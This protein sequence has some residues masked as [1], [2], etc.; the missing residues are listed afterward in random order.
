[1]RP[2]LTLLLIGLA[3]ALAA[4]EPVAVDRLLFRVSEAEQEPY[5]SRILV[6]P[7]YVRIDEGA[8]ER[9]FILYDREKRLIYSVNSGDKTVLVIEPGTRGAGGQGGPAVEVRRTPD[10]Q[11]PPIAGVKPV[12]VSLLAGGK[13][14]EERIVAPGLLVKAL[15]GLG[16]YQRTR[17]L[18]ELATL[19]AIPADMQDACDLALNVYHSDLLLKDGLPVR[20]WRQ[21]LKEDL[22]DFAEAV[23][24]PSQL[25]QLPEGYHRVRMN[26]LKSLQSEQR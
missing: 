20:R 18:Q 9:G 14:C 11:A 15:E 6:T 5:T 3:G 23:P 24:L 25:F 10:E 4:G 1:M 13:V 21:G 16:E 17:A 12:Q 2:F 26:D 8:D 22:V 19:G 7:G